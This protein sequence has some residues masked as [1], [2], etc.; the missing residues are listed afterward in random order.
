MR[1]ATLSALIFVLGVASARA[2]VPV[3]RWGQTF[4]SD[5][6]EVRNIAVD[7]AGYLYATGIVSGDVDVDGDGRIDVSTT[8]GESALY[9]AKYRPDD[10]HLVW[11]DHLRGD[12]SR[13]TGIA[14]DPSGG[15]IYVVGS[16]RGD[17]SFNPLWGQPER[18]C[19][20]PHDSSQAGLVIR[21]NADGQVQ[22]SRAMDGTTTD[23]LS[24]VQPRDVAY[25][26]GYL[27]VVGT[28]WH[29]L[30]ADEDG[31]A[32]LTAKGQEKDGFVLSMFAVDGGL[33]WSKQ[34]GGES[35]DEA[36][37]AAFAATTPVP[38]QVAVVG[39][40]QSPVDVDGNG[41]VDFTGSF[42]APVAF[43]L[44]YD[45]NGSAHLDRCSGRRI[46]GRRGIGRW[47]RLL[48]PDA[49]GSSDPGG[50]TDPRPAVLAKHAIALGGRLWSRVVTRW[51]HAD[52][53]AVAADRRGNAYVT[54]FFDTTL[55]MDG[56]HLVTIARAG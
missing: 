42:E 18:S 30:D 32:D 24:I 44:S 7:D 11:I 21:Y 22:W 39:Y 12:W 3:Y 51:G 26:G 6:D 27:T 52:V 41:S 29:D 45:W 33:R 1:A 16:F 2:E 5:R 50:S 43:L 35:Y 38:L 15:S 25:L 28:F 55:E 37:A 4:G 53:T 8:D 17:V 49:I 10:H 46:R 54:G 13:G 31:D 14:V 40:A 47:R 23:P 36:F 19:T 48:F 20:C 9:V 56:D 34:I